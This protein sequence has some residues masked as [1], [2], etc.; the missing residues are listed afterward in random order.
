M[1]EL[2]RKYNEIWPIEVV[3]EDLLDWNDW[4]VAHRVLQP[5]GLI[6]LGSYYKTS[7]ENHDKWNT[8]QGARW[9]SGLDNSPMYDGDIFDQETHMMQM[10]D[11]GMSSLFVQEA[12]SLA[13]LAEIVGAV[14]LLGGIQGVGDGRHQQGRQDGDDRNHHQ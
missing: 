11:V 3:F 1:L 7:A 13:E 14:S 4:F 5:E 2:Y 8:M 10:Y 6:A 9:E 12:Y